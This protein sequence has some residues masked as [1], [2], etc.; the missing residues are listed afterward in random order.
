MLRGTR[1]EWLAVAV[2][3]IVLSMLISVIKWSLVLKA[4]EIEVSWRDLWRAYWVGLFF[5]NFLP[6]SIGG[7]SVRALFVGKSLANMTGAASSVVIERILATAGLSLT[8]ISAVA[9]SIPASSRV[10]GLFIL[11][12]V[13]SLA[14]LFFISRDCN[15][16]QR[17]GRDGKIVRFLTGMTQQGC[18]IRSH[19]RE[20]SFAVFFSVLFQ[21][22]V[23][24]VNYA[25][26]RALLIQDVS[27]GAMFYVIPAISALAMI[28]VGINGYGV[29]EG[30][31]VTLLSAYGVSGG[32][33]VAVSLIFA[34]LVSFC[35]LYGGLEWLLYQDKGVLEHAKT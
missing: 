20:L 32:T 5:N 10:T 22:S 8:G 35:S 12:L 33:A 4:E 27:I 29:R 17:D 3:L 1:T 9:F 16:E 25:I 18:Y 14:F 31:Y 11:L 21:C 15:P 6:S 26:F 24:A 34:F 2:L 23:I 28:P 19:K 7:D 30:A 13:V